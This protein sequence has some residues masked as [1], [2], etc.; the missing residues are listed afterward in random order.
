MPA[1]TI[2]VA[3]DIPSTQGH[4][5]EKYLSTDAAEKLNLICQRI[6]ACH[7]DFSKCYPDAVIIY[8]WR[9]YGVVSEKD[10]NVTNDFKKEFKKR[11][12]ELTGQHPNMLVIAGTLP[13]SK[14]VDQEKL[15]TVASHYRQLDSVN[16]DFEKK[17]GSKDSLIINHHDQFRNAENYKKTSSLD[18]YAVRNVCY[19]FQN[20]KCTSRGKVMPYNETGKFSLT[21]M[22]H[23]YQPPSPDSIDP[24]YTFNHPGTGKPFSICVEICREHIKGLAK[25]KNVQ[26]D[27][28]VIISDWINLDEFSENFVARHVFHVDSK[29]ASKYVSFENINTDFDFFKVNLLSDMVIIDGPIRPVRFIYLSELDEKIING[30]EMDWDS[31]SLESDV[32]NDMFQLR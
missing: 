11:L 8:C 21:Y 7:A 3:L 9:E 31:I 2:F 20:G 27:M 5:F 13:F 26:A 17:T 1:K 23:F 16:A 24:V 14:K 22:P 4:Q 12:S 29:N 10:E 25:Y 6:Q 18:I 19:I 32:G 30:S 28:H 15:K